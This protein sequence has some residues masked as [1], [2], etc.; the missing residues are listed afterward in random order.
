M[1][2]AIL[3]IWGIG[4]A[5]VIQITLLFVMAIGAVGLD[6]GF[7]VAVFVMFIVVALVVGVFVY[8]RD[9]QHK[10]TYRNVQTSLK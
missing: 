6:Y 2:Q 4:R 3:T 9:K 7:G 1:C 8:R 10:T 5:G